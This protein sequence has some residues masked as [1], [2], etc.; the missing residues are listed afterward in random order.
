[1]REIIHDN[2]KFEFTLIDKSIF[3]FYLKAHAHVEVDDL[4]LNLKELSKHLVKPK[5]PFLIVFDEHMSVSEEVHKVFSTPE[6]SYYKNYEA[7][8]LKSPT[9]KFLAKNIIGLYPVSHE[10]KLFSNEADALAWIREKLA[11]EK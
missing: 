7:F 9:Q 3:R 8:V 4:T 11:E 1:M 6:R 2:E 5:M 10:R